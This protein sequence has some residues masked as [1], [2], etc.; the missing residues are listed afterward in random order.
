MTD[1][2]PCPAGTVAPSSD[3]GSSGGGGRESNP[4]A[5]RA[6]RSLVLKNGVSC[7]D[8]PVHGFSAAV[9]PGHQGSSGISGDETGSLVH[10]TGV[11]IPFPS[12]LT[13][14]WRGT[15]PVQGR[16]QRRKNRRGRAQFT[17]A[18]SVRRPLEVRVHP[19]QRRPH[20]PSSGGAVGSGQ[21]LAIYRSSSGSTMSRSSR[22]PSRSRSTSIP[23]CPVPSVSTVLGLLPLRTFP[24]SLTT[25]PFFSWP[26]CSVISCI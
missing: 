13:W 23:T 5:T 7:D 4:P 3:V 20:Q 19:Q 15:G 16:C 12:E 14:G 6:R 25:W 22:A 2:R 18:S 1:C 8:C 24:V 21:L 11:P 9:R 26:R 10:R 17:S